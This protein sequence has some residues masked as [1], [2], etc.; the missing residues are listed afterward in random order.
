MDSPHGE[1]LATPQESLIRMMLGVEC[2]QSRV[3]ELLLTK[4][5]ELIQQDQE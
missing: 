2:I 5:A 3:I 1:N 4:L